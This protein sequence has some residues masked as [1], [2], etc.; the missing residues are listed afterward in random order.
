MTPAPMPYITGIY[1]GIIALMLLAF[2]VR[3]SRFRIVYKVGIGAGGHGMLERAIRVH[4]NTMEW[5]LPY[6]FLMLIAELDRARP[7]AL[8]LFGIALIVGRI[9]HA[10]GLSRWPGQSMGRA[11]GTGITWVGLAVLALRAIAS[12]VRIALSS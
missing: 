6:L 3:I 8:H 5:S 1:A 12:G 11:V 4:A 10:Y 7:L 2:A 9:L